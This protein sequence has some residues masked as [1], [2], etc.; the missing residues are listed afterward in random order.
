MQKI[1]KHIAI[2]MDGN[3][4]WAKKKGLPFKAGHQE[5]VGALKKIVNYAGKIGVKYLTV[6][7]FSTE[8]KLRSKIEVAA[9]Y[10]LFEESLEKE[11]PELNQNNVYLKFIGNLL[12]LPKPFQKKAK[13]AESILKKNTGLRFI[14]ALNYGSRAEI[15]KAAQNSSS[16]SEKSIAKNLYTAGL[17]ELDLLIRTGGEQRLSNFLLWQ[18]AYSELYFTKVLWPDFKESDFMKA[19]LDYNN[20]QRRFGK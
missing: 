14:I 7:A 9:L 11:I 12:E 5:G 3:R 1:P 18:V 6:F 20:R 15:V 2:I 13:K 8:N 4:R 19:I 17:P 10:K 16:V